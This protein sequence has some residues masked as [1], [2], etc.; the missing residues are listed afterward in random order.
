MI[1][2]FSVYCHYFNDD[3]KQKGGGTDTGLEIVYSSVQIF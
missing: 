1:F 3:K 2:L